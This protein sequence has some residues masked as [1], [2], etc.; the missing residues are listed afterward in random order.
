M[1]Y[2][3]IKDMLNMIDEP[4][5]SACHKLY[6]DNVDLFKRAK[7]STYNHQSWE[8]GYHDHITEVMNICIALY[9][10][11]RIRGLNFTLSDAL[12]VMFLHDLEKPWKDEISKE[13]DKLP[14]HMRLSEAHYG[15][16]KIRKVFR[17]TKI[18]E[19]GIELMPQQ[20]NALKYVEGEG[21][22]YS[23]KARV[24]NELAAFCHIA[25]VS[26]ARIWHNFP[27]PNDKLWSNLLRA[28]MYFLT[29]EEGGRTIPPIPQKNNFG[30]CI[31]YISQEKCYCRWSVGLLFDEIKPIELGKE[32]DVGVMFVASQAFEC[33]KSGDELLCYEGATLV[34]RGKVI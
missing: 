7:G 3:H 28:K 18:K 31:T 11:Y 33:F 19:Y 9:P 24:M 15:F 1:S 30:N 26:S 17:E 10:I 21:E 6:D 27:N 5:R 16:K 13:I 2:H 32:Y 29:A 22:D 8:G 4:Y 14:L 25:D 23:S 12:L 34:A 20:Q